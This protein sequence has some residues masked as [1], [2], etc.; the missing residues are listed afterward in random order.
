MIDALEPSPRSR[1]IRTMN[2]KPKPLGSARREKARTPRWPRSGSPPS[3]MLN[4]FQ[5]S[6]AAAAQSNPG[7]IFAVVA[8]ARTR[9]APLTRAGSSENLDDRAN[10]HL[11]DLRADP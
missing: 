4:S 11:D 2:S 3:V 9:T 5:R 8:G 7:P 10:V 1:G 6:N